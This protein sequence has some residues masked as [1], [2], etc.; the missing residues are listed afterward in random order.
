MNPKARSMKVR[1]VLMELVFGDGLE[2]RLVVVDFVRNF[3]S[4][5]K[6]N[7]GESHYVCCSFSAML[8]AH[9]YFD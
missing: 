2:Q 1:L 3:V 9:F 4:A 7:S 8:W 5:M 6:R